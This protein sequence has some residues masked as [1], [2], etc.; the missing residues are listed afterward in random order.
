MYV[1][2]RGLGEEVDPT[3]EQMEIARAVQAAL[4]SHRPLERTHGFVA[5]AIGGAAAAA[6]GAKED[7]IKSIIM[8]AAIGATAEFVAMLVVRR[9]EPRL[10]GE[11][12]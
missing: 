3:P 6:F 9:V 12:A 1:R 4:H 7:R 8:G 11:I 5:A 10:V 2:Q